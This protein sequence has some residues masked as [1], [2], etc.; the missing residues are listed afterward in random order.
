MTTAQDILNQR[1]VLKAIQQHRASKQTEIDRLH[2]KMGAAFYNALAPLPRATNKVDYAMQLARNAFNIWQGI[3]I[4]MK[5]VRG[6][7]SAFGRK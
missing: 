7:R 1:D 3:T 4:G 5:V 2:K 6:F